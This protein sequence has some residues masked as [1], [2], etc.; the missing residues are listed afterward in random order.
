MDYVFNFI[1]L[2]IIIKLTIFSK[3]IVA[4]YLF[5]FIDIFR[6]FHLLE[7]ASKM[8]QNL[9]EMLGINHLESHDRNLMQ[10]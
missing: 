6:K 9:L 5:I 2:F 10:N 1:S 8:L 4:V 3:I 7:L